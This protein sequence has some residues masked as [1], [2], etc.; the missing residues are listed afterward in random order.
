M[1]ARSEV[2]A[3]LVLSLAAMACRSLPPAR[4]YV[5]TPPE[6]AVQSEGATGEGLRL[7]VEAFSVDSPYDGDQ[8]AYR[9]GLD[10]PEI[11]FYA[12]HRWAASL[13]HQLPLVAAAIF[14]NLPTVAS[15]TPVAAGRSHDAVL[16]GRLLYLEE[17]DLPGE[18]IA[19]VGLE[20][21]LIDQDDRRVWSQSVAA[22]VGGQA[23]EVADIVRS[24]R[25][26]VQKAFDQVRPSL[27]AAVL[28]LSEAH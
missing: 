24:M 6:V 5:I 2:C 17:L 15:I 13:R 16:V 12:H 8:I 9:V 18:Q 20:L 22:Q 27:K 11:S 1:R 10:S 25:Q 14:A 21:E 19:R 4:L 26:A 3:L 28:G 23:D 7:A